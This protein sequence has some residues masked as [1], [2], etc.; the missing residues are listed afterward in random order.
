MTSPNFVLWSLKGGVGKSSISANL[1]YTLGYGI[2]TND[3]YSPIEKVMPKGRYSKLLPKQDIPAQV[4]QKNQG[5]L[6]DFGGYL[7]GRIKDAVKVSKYVMIPIIEA[8]DFNIQGL[9]SSIAELSTITDKIIIILN[10][11]KK[12]QMVLI[13]SELRRHEYP[14]PIFE[15]GSS[16]ALIRVI[17]QK[18][19]IRDMVKRGGLLGYMYKD[20]SEQFERLISYLIK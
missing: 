4:L 1:A 7:D 2:V 16:T 6:F 15:I 12:D 17:R 13:K 18:E 3:V 11:M 8:D 9:I 20:V 19:S 14:Y 5:I 10:K